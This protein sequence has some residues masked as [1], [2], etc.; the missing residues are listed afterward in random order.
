MAAKKSPET[1]S[2]VEANE[3]DPGPDPAGPGSVCALRRVLYRAGDVFGFSIGYGYG[4]SHVGI[5]APHP[6]RRDDVAL[7]ESLAAPGQPCIVRG[8]PATGVQCHDLCPRIKQYDGRVWH[9]PLAKPLTFTCRKRLDFESVNSIGIKYDTPGAW[10]PRS[11]GLIE[12]LIE[13]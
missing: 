11:V 8:A 6:W 12:W 9:Y 4:I 10:R 7:Y 13:F 1:S 3:K 2:A 5:V